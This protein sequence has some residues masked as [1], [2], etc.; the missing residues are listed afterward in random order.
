MDILIF[1]HLVISSCGNHKL[2]K[3]AYN[4]DWSDINAGLC[5]CFLYKPNGLLTGC[6]GHTEKYRTAVFVQPEPARAVLKDQGPVFL[7]MARAN[8]V[9]KPF[10]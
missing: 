5:I 8:S 3:Q 1:Y 4:L 7:S 9:N 2:I 6:E 10:I